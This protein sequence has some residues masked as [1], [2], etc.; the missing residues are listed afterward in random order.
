MTMQS[1]AQGSIRQN[2]PAR[3]SQVILVVLICSVFHLI[4]FAND[5][6][7]GYRTFAWGDRGE[8]RVSFL[9]EFTSTPHTDVIAS[10][11]SGGTVP[12][13]Y[14][15]VVGPYL[16]FGKAGVILFQIALS[17]ASAAATARLGAELL[18]FRFS[19]LITGL[20]Y[21][22]IPQNLVYPHQLVTEAIAT[23]LCVG[24][25]YFTYQGLMR[26]SRGSLIAA[27]LLLGI[28]IFVRP[29][30]FAIILTFPLLA[31][32][33]RRLRFLLTNKW[34]YAMLAL[35]AAPLLTWTAIFTAYSGH[36][37][38]ANGVTTLSW[39]L[40]DKAR[41]VELANDIPLSASLVSDKADKA[42]IPLREARY[43]D[44]SGGIS[45]REFGQIALQHPVPFLKE[46]VLDAV[47]AFGRGN[48]TKFTVDYLGIE[49]DQKNWRD[50]IIYDKSSA[51]DFAK[52]L[53]PYIVIEVLTSALTLALSCVCLI[54]LVHEL[55][56]SGTGQS[57]FVRRQ[58]VVFSALSA[59]LIAHTFLSA[60]LVG[61]SQGR[62]RNPAEAAMIITAGLAYYVFRSRRHLHRR[63]GSSFYHQ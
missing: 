52:F 10:M 23:P 29:S 61:E 15:F 17:V 31:L 39:N 2:E 60:Q 3:F 35:A 42:G 21:T 9:Q 4:L 57:E 5:V 63:D 34:I 12:G 20:L 53:K 32:F 41:A 47:V 7:S 19:A 28:A 45:L 55:F 56:G 8:G 6:Q 22:L 62:L 38:F 36:L 13:E 18:P 51:R 43:L 48:S 40:R 14:L 44:E 16:A 54:Y 11:V 50:G 59:S 30:L 37:G 25:L 1:N 49:R 33:I 26:N 46:F 24:W 27:G 58:R